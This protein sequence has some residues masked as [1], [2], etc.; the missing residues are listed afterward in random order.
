MLTIKYVTEK[1][2]NAEFKIKEWS[3]GEDRP[4]FS[5]NFLWGIQ[6]VTA[7]GPEKDHLC[8]VFHNLPIKKGPSTMWIGDFAKFIVSNFCILE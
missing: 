6:T 5:V 2:P 1:H 8:E 4:L 3:L 7:D